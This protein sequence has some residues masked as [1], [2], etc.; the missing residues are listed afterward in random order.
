MMKKKKGFFSGAE[1][2]VD[3]ERRCEDRN[4]FQ[5]VQRM[6]RV[7]EGERR[8][9]LHA[10]YP[11]LGN[12]G[13]LLKGCETGLGGEGEGEWR[14]SVGEWGLLQATGREF[15]FHRRNLVYCNRRGRRGE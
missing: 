12:G 10:G 4:W 13:N 9:C 7:G 5:E 11:K 1:G 6:K 14:H 8:N 2:R 15:P 3:N